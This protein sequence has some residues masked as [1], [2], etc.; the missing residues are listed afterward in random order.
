MT[1]LPTQLE[2]AVALLQAAH[3]KPVTF[4][5]TAAFTGLLGSLY[6][7]RLRPM[8]RVEAQQTYQIQIDRQTGATTITPITAP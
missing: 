5:F 7:Y 4:E 1:T 6:D 8:V 3:A 2:E